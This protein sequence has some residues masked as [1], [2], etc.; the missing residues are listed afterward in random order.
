MGFVND[1]KKWCRLEPQF[2]LQESTKPVHIVR[3]KL[4]LIPVI[5]LTMRSRAATLTA[6]W[7][8]LFSFYNSLRYTINVCHLETDLC[9]TKY[10]S[11]NNTSESPFTVSL[12]F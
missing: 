5:H 1:L 12:T 9:C 11:R 3:T 2:S 10:V 8:N 4:C 7:I 6:S